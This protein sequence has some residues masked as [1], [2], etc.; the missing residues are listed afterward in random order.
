MC[1][2]CGI[3]V[4]GKRYKCLICIDYDECSECELFSK[5]KHPMMRL[6]VPMNNKK[7][8]KVSEL[9][10]FKLNSDF[11]KIGDFRFRINL[12]RNL[13]NNHYP[14]KFYVKLVN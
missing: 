12:L 9:F 10:R 3:D 1:N 4:V 6:L 2:I 8:E 7:A 14:E 11:G 5:H 13:T